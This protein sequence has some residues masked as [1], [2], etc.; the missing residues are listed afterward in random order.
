VFEDQYL[1][2]TLLFIHLFGTHV[3]CCLQLTS[4][5][6]KG[7]NI[8]GLGEVVSSSGF[9]RAIG[10]NGDNG[11]IQTMWARDIA[12]PIDQNM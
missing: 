11:T 2:V 12:D 6:P 4:A 7:T 9:R 10:T 3:L 5:L 8:Y 1:Q